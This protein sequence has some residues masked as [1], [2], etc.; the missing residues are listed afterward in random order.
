MLAATLAFTS[1]DAIIKLTG[2]VVPVGQMLFIRG[3]FVMALLAVAIWATGALSRWQPEYTFLTVVRSFAEIVSTVFFFLG[4][5]T[6]AFAEASAIGQTA[7][8][9]VT[10]G[11]AL[12]LGE[13]V[14][15]RR[16][17]AT[18]IGFIGV[19]FIVRPGGDTFSWGAVLILISTM[20][21]A[22]R[23]LLT[24]QMPHGVPSLVL[25]FG[26]GLG[27]TIV[28]FAMRIK[29]TWVSIP[30]GEMVQLMISACTVIL[31]YLSIIAASRAGDMSVVSPFRYSAILFGLAIGITV[32]GEK[33][34]WMTAIGIVLILGAGL[35]TLWREHIRRQEAQNQVS[36]LGEAA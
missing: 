12:F 6:I 19:L 10:A 1:G 28:G 23:D 33:I 11:A 21:V 31:G 16:W 14:G 9:L 30:S 8:L 34:T 20:G 3:L 24:R 7:P 13:K 18:L 22:F 29:E 17:V 5:M 35:Y 2:K 4:L 25:A 36:R 27:V 15:W 32:F 26:A